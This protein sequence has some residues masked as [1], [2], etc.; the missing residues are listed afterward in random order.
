MAGDATE[1]DLRSWV[2]LDVEVVARAQAL[3]FGTRL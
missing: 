2:A 3:G 1:A